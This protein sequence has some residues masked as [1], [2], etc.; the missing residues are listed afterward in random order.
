MFTRIFGKPKQEANTLTTL[1]KLNEVSWIWI[2]QLRDYF[3]SNPRIVQVDEY[4]LLFKLCVS[5]I[6]IVRS[7]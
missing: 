7:E 4:N 3:F 5:Y 6:Y 2:S 1:D